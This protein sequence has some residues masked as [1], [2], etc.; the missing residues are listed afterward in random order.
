MSDEDDDDIQEISDEDDYSM[1]S[2]SNARNGS[3]KSTQATGRRR[4]AVF[5]EDSDDD[6]SFDPPTRKKRR[7]GRYVC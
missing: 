6:Y 3:R 7:W 5:D 4:G 1:N 2:R